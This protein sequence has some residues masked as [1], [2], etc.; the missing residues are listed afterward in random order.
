MSTK[1][2]HVAIA[3]MLF[4][5]S[6]FAA[7]LELSD[8]AKKF[9]INTKRSIYKVTTA[10]GN[11][12]DIFSPKNNAG[13]FLAYEIIKMKRDDKTISTLSVQTGCMV[14]YHEK[15]GRYL[16]YNHDVVK[17]P[18]INSSET[19]L[20]ELKMS[21]TK[22]LSNLIADDAD[23]FVF[24]NTETDSAL[25]ESD[26]RPRLVSISYRFTRQL[27]GRHVVDNT[28]FVRISFSGNNQISEFEIANPAFKPVFLRSVVK[29][30][31]SDDRLVNYSENMGKVINNGG[32][33]T[34]V[35]VKAEKGYFTYLAANKDDKQYLLPHISFYTDQ[36]LENNESFHTW[37]HFCLDA[38]MTP[39]LDSTMIEDF[40]IKNK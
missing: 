13:P 2:F 10:H 36:I 30:S 9:I 23:N 32:E 12:P 24:S 8:N 35:A 5:I 26:P 16:G 33:Y 21:A 11:S 19:N 1:L 31:F 27:N 4:S 6:S 3:C 22:E 18:L 15:F 25:S 39:G 14:K 34:V 7:N 40:Q 38:S 20:L 28:A 17:I 29:E 37:V